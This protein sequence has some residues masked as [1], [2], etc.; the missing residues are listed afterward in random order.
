MDCQQKSEAA[1]IPPEGQRRRHKGV[2]GAPH[3]QSSSTAGSPSA[4]G[5]VSEEGEVCEGFEGREQSVAAQ[6]VARSSRGSATRLQTSAPDVLSTTFRG[7]ALDSL[8]SLGVA[9][10]NSNELEENV[11]ER[12]KAAFDAEVQ[13]KDA[14]DGRGVRQGAGGWEGSDDDDDGSVDQA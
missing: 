10:L 11:I 6:S 3:T 14:V 13:Q 4:D 8:Q 5:C 7:S 12:A 9:M 2:T 1:T